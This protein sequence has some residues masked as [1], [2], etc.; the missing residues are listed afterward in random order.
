MV[1]SVR[2]LEVI[3]LLAITFLFLG[4]IA[5]SFATTELEHV[6]ANWNERRCE[7]LVMLIAQMIPKEAEIDRSAFSADNFTFCMGNLMDSVLQLF[8]GPMMQVFGNQVKA[9]DTIQGVTNTMKGSAASL[10][11]PLQDIFGSF[12]TKLTA[13]AFRINMVFVK[14]KS[15]MDRLSTISLAKVFAGMSMMRAILNSINYVIRAVLIILTI[16]VVLVIFLWFVL[17]PYIPIILTVITIIAATA[18]G[19]AASGMAG[20]FCVIPGTEIALEDGT[21]RAVELLRPGDRLASPGG[22]NVIEG[23]LQTTGR[24]ASLVSIKGVTLS[25]EHL[26]YYEEGQKWI[27]AGKYP[28]AKVVYNEVDFLY[29]LNTSNHTWTARGKDGSVLLRDWEELPD[30]HDVEW[31]GMVYELLNRSALASLDPLIA[32]AGRGL[33]GA[34][35]MI[36]TADRGFVPAYEVKVGDFIADG[37][38]GRHTSADA[39]SANVNYVEVLGVYHDTA[40]SVP[41]SGLNNACW[42]YYEGKGVWRHPSFGYG[43]DSEPVSW[44]PM[45]MNGYHFITSSGTFIAGGYV[46]RDFTEVGIHRIDQTYAFVEH[47]LH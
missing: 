21:W 17:F 35:T 46:I 12:H 27:L 30:G 25:K 18:A 7:P 16:L 8:I 32:G 28:G 39:T 13:V 43:L 26:V 45:D 4:S 40:T 36:L 23:V 3:P 44:S 22:P 33:L 1:L 15:I 14:I 38:N 31:G 24:G 9:A 2:M 11:K 34:N 6:R 29:C 47:R 5:Y 19:A 10:I 41:S 20:S 37:E 42:I